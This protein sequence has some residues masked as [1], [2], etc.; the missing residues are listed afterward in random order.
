M[1]PVLE[2][3]GR[4]RL[5]ASALTPRLCLQIEV[6]T[7]APRPKDPVAVPNPGTTAETLKLQ[8]PTT[9]GPVR[10]APVPPQG[11][12]GPLG[13]AQ[14]CSRQGLVPVGC[15]H[16][17][18]GG[19]GW[20]SGEKGANP[21]GT[22]R[23]QQLFALPGV[24]GVRLITQQAGGLQRDISGKQEFQQSSNILMSRGIAT[25]GQSSN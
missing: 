22:G 23:Q 3:S 4:T 17:S 19:Q 20:C 18:Q 16:M 7:L 21:F 25:V 24:L 14:R 8:P 10:P 5:A 13:A 2:G 1:P 9:A 12:C 6:G 11:E 15:S